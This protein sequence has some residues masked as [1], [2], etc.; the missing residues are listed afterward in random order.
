MEALEDDEMCAR[1]K[2]RGSCCYLETMA[3]GIRISTDEPCEFLDEETGLCKVYENRYDVNPECL[4]IEEMLEGHTV[5]LECGYI[6]DKD[7]Y[8]KTKNRRYYKYAI[9]TGIEF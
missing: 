4:T 1:C 9:S 5:P 6:K 7:G 2:V 8:E 3:K